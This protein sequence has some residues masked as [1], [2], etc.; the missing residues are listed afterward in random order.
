VRAWWDRVLDD[1]SARA[2]LA[3]PIADVEAPRSGVLL[4]LFS[5]LA[6]IAN[7]CLLAAL[8]FAFAEPV[9]GWAT[10]G[11]VL[12]MAVLAAASFLGGAWS[13]SARFAW[14]VGYLNHVGVTLALGGLT[15][16]GGYLMFGIANTV[17]NFVGSRTQLA[18][19]A[20]IYVA[21]ALALA[22]ADEAIRAAIDPPDPELL[23]ILFALVFVT[24]LVILLILVRSYA[25]GLA[26]ERHRSEDLRRRLD[27]LI[28]HYLAPEVAD[29]LI[30]DPT[31][32]SLG[33]EEVEATVLFAD[34]TGFTSFSE[35]V[36][37]SAAIAM[38]SRSFGPA[39]P[40]VRDEGGTVV[41]FSGDALM[42]VFNA[43]RPQPDHALRAARAALR[44]QRA[45]AASQDVPGA[46]RFRV[47]LTTG[48]VV[49]G[50]IGTADLHSFTAIGDT[51]NLAARLQTFAQP[52]SVVIDHHTRLLLGDDA[53]VRSLGAQ[54]LKGKAAPVM[55]YELT[56]LR[57][58]ATHDAI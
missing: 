50:N 41:Q 44:L 23:A 47:G 54:M 8:F 58:S 48:P 12:S 10:V 42:A 45:A 24:I 18:A 57:A 6:A 21:T 39:V 16:S 35:Q 15:Q 43:P 19:Y 33:G 36:S 40:A 29:E 51:T 22:V 38:L 55:C 25:E 46:P 2:R 3:G 9:A 14:T 34:L 52:G 7:S 1:A 56:G 11:Y 37:P 32:D 26:S 53:E 31:R 17:M 49:V 20:S 28:H 4:G 13:T 27:D 30:A 5:Y